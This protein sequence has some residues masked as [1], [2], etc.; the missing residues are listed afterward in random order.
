MLYFKNGVKIPIP[1]ALMQEKHGRI[2]RTHLL[3]E[4]EQG[5]KQ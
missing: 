4:E 3:F 1:E 5:I 2:I